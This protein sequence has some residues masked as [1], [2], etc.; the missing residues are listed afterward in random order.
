MD[1]LLER[2]DELATL[3]AA[4]E[5]ALAEHGSLVLVGGEAGSGKSSLIRGFRERVGDRALFVVVCCEPLSVPVPLAP[6]RALANAIG[7]AD[8]L[9]HHAGDHVALAAALH[10]ALR[11]CCPAVVVVEDA[12]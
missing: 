12:H 6:V 4:F 5:A 1:R 3:G 8:L 7:A 2:E 11:A 9:D 10:D